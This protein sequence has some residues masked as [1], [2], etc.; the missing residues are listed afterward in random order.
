MDLTI[1]ANAFALRD[2]AQKAE[3]GA[4]AFEAADLGK[5]AEGADNPQSLRPPQE[6]IAVKLMMRAMKI[7]EEASANGEKE[8]PPSTELIVELLDAATAP[9]GD[10]DQS[11]LVGDGQIVVPT[12]VGVPRTGEAEPVKPK[13]TAGK[14][15]ARG[16]RKKK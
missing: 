11:L 7:Q 10:I 16:K 15:G 8:G 4:E 9:L 12:V 1:F 13:R 2:E 14:K 6:D 5:F 3:I